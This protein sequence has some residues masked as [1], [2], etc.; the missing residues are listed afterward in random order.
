M[1]TSTRSTKKRVLRAVQKV[2]KKRLT[3]VKR[4]SVSLQKKKRKTSKYNDGFVF[5]FLLFL[6]WCCF[7]FVAGNKE[8]V[9]PPST[10]RLKKA[11]IKD[12]PEKAPTTKKNIAVKKKKG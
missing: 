8:N 5:F 7:Y 4:E 9:P 3:K 2:P 11:S 10:K 1:P 12:K 6:P